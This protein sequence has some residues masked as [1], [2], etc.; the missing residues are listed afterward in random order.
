[1]NSAAFQYSGLVL[2]IAGQ[3][4]CQPAAPMGLTSGNQEYTDRL[5]K[6]D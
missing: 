1:M 3:R 2:L 5:P 4:H 6:G